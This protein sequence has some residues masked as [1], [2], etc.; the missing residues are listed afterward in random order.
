MLKLYGK[1]VRVASAVRVRL[2][3]AV[4]S[5]LYGKNSERYWNARFLTNWESA[6]GGLQTTLFA[7]GLASQD[8]GIEPTSILDY[9]C[10]AGQSLPVLR[11]RFPRCDLFYW[12][13]SSVAM[14]IVRGRYHEFAR[15]HVPGTIYDCVYCSNVI[16]HVVDLPG[17]LEAVASMAKHCVVIQAPLDERHPDGSELSVSRPIDEHI[18]TVK[19]STVPELLA[20]FHWDSFVF[21]VPTAWKGSQ[22]AFVGIRKD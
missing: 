14:E 22:V 9:G 19:I 17:I 20:G 4:F 18:R 10:G 15:E 11:M 1:S 13:H 8:I 6:G 12:D 2:E 21:Q 16:E 7:A 3:N 5:I